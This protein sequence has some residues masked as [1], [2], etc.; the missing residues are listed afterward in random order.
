MSDIRLKLNEGE[1]IAFISDVH[2]DSKMPDSRVD[3]IITTLKDKLVDIFNKCIAELNNVC[4][5]N[6]PEDRSLFYDE[7]KYIE[8]TLT[9]IEKKKFSHRVL[10]MKILFLVKSLKL[11]KIKT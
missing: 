4:E 10:S 8:R 1:K 11:I 9:L 2:V 6:F 3:D 7:E 5:K